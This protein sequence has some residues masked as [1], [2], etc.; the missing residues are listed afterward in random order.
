MGLKA[1]SGPPSCCN[2]LLHYEL[3]PPICSRVFVV[4][5]FGGFEFS[6]LLTEQGCFLE[7][8]VAVF[9][10][11]FLQIELISLDSHS[12]YSL[13]KKCS[14][15][16][17]IFYCYWLLFQD[18]LRSFSHITSFFTS[19]AQRRSNLEPTLKRTHGPIKFGTNQIAK[20]FPAGKMARLIFIFIFI[21][22]K[23]FKSFISFSE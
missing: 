14:H 2:S 9:N 5:S 3:R 18:R 20:P 7:F 4:S 22:S 13:L 16:K 19:L 23:H 12:S 6:R 11:Y 17:N 1:G 8:C 15:E 10:R 21:G